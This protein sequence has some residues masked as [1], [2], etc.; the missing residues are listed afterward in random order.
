MSIG[1]LGNIVFETSASKVRTF[2]R[3][4]RRGSAAFAEHAV[5][6]SKPRLQ[7]IGSGLDEVSFSIKFDAALG[8]NPVEEL[9]QVREILRRGE[10]QIL[11]ISEDRTLGYFVLTEVRETWRQVDKAGHLLAVTLDITLKEVSHGN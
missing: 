2:D 1:T 3:F 8:L 5:L 10:P 4:S 11:K 9:E 6:D 7:H